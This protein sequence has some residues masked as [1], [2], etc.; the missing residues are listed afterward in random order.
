MTNSEPTRKK[1]ELEADENFLNDEIGFARQL[2]EIRNFRV[3]AKG[4]DKLL[5]KQIA[6]G[7]AAERLARE[8]LIEGVG[9]YVLRVARSYEGRGVPLE[10]LVQEG[11]MGVLRAIGLYQPEKGYAF[12]TYADDWIRQRMSRACTDRGSLEKYHMRMPCHMYMAIGR[13]Q[14]AL[15]RLQDELG[16]EPSVEELVERLA[17]LYPTR[18]SASQVEM[19]LTVLA[20]STLSLD[21]QWSGEDSEVSVGESIADEQAAQPLEDLASQEARQAIWKAFSQLDSEEQEVLHLRL[22][23]DGKGRKFTQEQVCEKMGIKKSRLAAIQ[24][25]ALA[26]LRASAEMRELASSEVLDAL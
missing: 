4:E 22:R 8:R 6:K 10:E 25:R 7:G 18:T 14:K 16:R 5:F 20:R 26:K 15:P 19:A 2:R 3:L 17:Q 13:V 24:N 11:N 21:S 12:L 1:S 23:L 9:Q